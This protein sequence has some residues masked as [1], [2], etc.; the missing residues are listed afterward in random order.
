MK[1]LFADEM[2]TEKVATKKI[3]ENINDWPT[4]IKTYLLETAPYVGKYDLV[5]NF[6]RTDEET[7]YGFGTVAISSGGK[8]VSAPFVIKDRQLFPID[9]IAHDGSIRPMTES[10]LSEGLFRPQLFDAVVKDEEIKPSNMVGAASNAEPPGRIGYNHPV[11]K[12]SSLLEG[13]KNTILEDDLRKTAEILSTN[14]SLR[15]RVFANPATL[16]AVK[17]LHEAETLEKKASLSAEIRPTVLQI[18]LVP[19]NKYKVKTANPK[20]YSKKEE[21][22]E[23]AHALVKFG[24]EVVRA[25]DNVGTLTISTDALV[26]KEKIETKYAE[27]ETNGVYKAVCLDGNPIKGIVLAKLANLDGTPSSIRLFIT[28]D[29]L[30]MQENIVGEKLGSVTSTMLP[31]GSPGGLGVFYWDTPSGMKATVPLVVHSVIKRAEEVTYDISS[32]L[33]DSTTL[34]P[35]SVKD[36]AKVGEEVLIPQ[37]AKFMALPGTSVLPIASKD[38]LEYR[39]G[40]D[41]TAKVNIRY[42]GKFSFS[43]ACGLDKIAGTEDLDWDDA[44]FLSTCLGM[45][46]EFAET[47]L[48]QAVK[49]QGGTTIKGLREIK[50]FEDYVQQAREKLASVKTPLSLYMDRIRQSLWKEAASIEDDNTVDKVLSLGFINPENISVFVENLPQIEECQRKLCELL[51]GSRLGLKQ[52]DEH[53]VSSAIKGV[54]KAIEGLKVLMHTN[55]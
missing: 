13:I 1:S 19:G 47:K 37:D 4:D 55:T 26:D 29:A 16:S 3:S 32:L 25:V 50:P 12:T 5:V 38:D 27:A 8:T 14:I 30:S 18:S 42:N 22:L 41:K 35:C 10:R 53:S 31:S 52:V 2:G 6:K 43:G 45:N 33:G 36:L 21:V 46:P 44:M 9:L 51:L 7:G 49:Y 23:R 17:L 15:D 34:C 40:Q 20:A 39:R 24:S 48:A 54:E 28:S 11:V